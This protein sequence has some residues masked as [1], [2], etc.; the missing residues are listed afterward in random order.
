MATK[1]V[2]SGRATSSLGHG[3]YPPPFTDFVL[4]ETP[5]PHSQFSFRQGFASFRK[6]AF[7]ILFYFFYSFYFV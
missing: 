5:H 2:V 7:I 3:L 4:A 6:Q 1:T